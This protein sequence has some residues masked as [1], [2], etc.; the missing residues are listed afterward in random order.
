MT[1][2][3][4]PALDGQ[5]FGAYLAQPATSNA[6]A[7]IVVQEIFGVNA[8]MR[9][10]CDDLARLGYLA[11]CPDL[12]W[13]QERNV[14]LTDKTDA[15]MQAAFKLYKGFDVELGLT[16]L[17]ATLAYARKMPGCNGAVGT[18][19]YC[20]GG[21]LAFLF[22]TRSDID[23][24]VSY[25]A[26]DLEKYLGDVADIRRPVLMHIAGDDE[27]VPPDARAKIL[28]S[29]GRNRSIKTEQYLS[30]KHAFARPEGVHY[31]PIAATMADERTA[32]F[33]AEN[34]RR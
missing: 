20:L 1:D 23:C 2:L 34:L 6:A 3:Q 9:K 4:I 24:A 29:V 18:V 11:L 17:L 14:Q 31:D 30:A 33:F 5:S 25:Y 16:D 19:G 15:E 26:V 8:A 27:F 13:R 32:D 22:A 28:R 12:F 10:I 7:V 21:K